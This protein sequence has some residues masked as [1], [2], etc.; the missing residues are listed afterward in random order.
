MKYGALLLLAV[1]VLSACERQPTAPPLA[2]NS[3]G[4]VFTSHDGDGPPPEESFPNDTHKTGEYTGL[5]TGTPVGLI[6]RPVTS[7]G[8]ACTGFLPSVTV[9]GTL[10]DVNLQIP[11]GEGPHP[12]IVQMHGW[13]GSKNTSSDIANVLVGD[14]YAVLRY[15]ARGFGD[16]WG[17]ANFGEIHVEA[18]DLQGMVGQVMDRPDLRLNPDA[19]AVTGASYGGAHSWLAAA[20]PTFKSPRGTSVRIRTVVPIAFGSDLLYSLMPSGKPRRSIDLIGGLKLSYVNGLYFAGIREDAERPYFNYPEYLAAWHAY[21][22]AQEPTPGDP[23]YKQIADGLAGYR[24][25]WWG[26]RARESDPDFW[27]TVAANPLPIFQVQGFTDDL[28]PLDEAKRMLLALKTLNASYPIATYLGDLGHPRASNKPGEVQHVMDLARQWFAFYLKGEGTQPPF[29]MYAAVTRPRDQA[30]NSG[31][32]I[33]LGS[34]SELSTRAVGWEF[35][36]T[37]FIAN[38][39]TDPYS[40]FKWDPLVMEGAQELEP[41]TL[42][43]LPQPVS[44]GVVAVYE[45]HAGELNGGAPVVVAGQPAVT[46]QGSVVGVRVQLNVRVFD[47]ASDGT[48]SLITRGTYTHESSTGALIGDV[49]LTIP[50]YGNVW[51]VPAEHRIRVEITNLDSPYIAP[52]K[53]PSATTISNVKLSIPVCTVAHPACTS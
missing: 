27:A 7:G 2:G 40:G 26:Y 50:T 14:G 36:E 42:P 19:V 51:R 34:Y 11:A 25:V 28:F 12:L 31:D 15:S 43:E 30:F 48:K 1:L 10:L 37:K 39:S 24:S 5:G 38:P 44:D 18:R 16:S 53:L 17:Q 32:V 4:P 23:V 41:Y 9:D 46:I 45:V 8:K 47:V 20:Q 22:N 6:C 29:V 33:T 13:G 3:G 21:V 52:S 35:T 49:T